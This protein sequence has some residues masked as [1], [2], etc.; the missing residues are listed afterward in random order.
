MKVN[1]AII[2]LSILVLQVICLSAQNAQPSLHQQMEWLRQTKK[3]NFVYDSSLKVDIPYAG[4][5]IRKMPVKKAL[6]TLFEKTDIEYVI[7]KN[8]V[9]LKRSQKQQIST[10]HTN[11]NHKVQQV[12]RRHTLSGYVRDKG[13]ESLINATVYD[14]THS[15]GT[16]TNEYG[17]FSITLP[18]GDHQIRFSYVGYAD[19]VEKINLSKDIHYN[20]S[21]QADSKL[22]EIVVNGDLNSPLL[23]TQ[24]GKR[25]FSSKDI[26][27]EFSLMSSPDVVKTLQRVSGVAEGQELASGLYVHGGNG[28]ENLFLIDGTPLY[29]INHALGLFSSFNTDVVKNIDFY[30]S[31]FPARYA[32]RLSSVIDVRTTDGDMNHFH[33]SYR[34]G[35]L[36]ASMQFEGPI[37]TGK[38]SYNIG[39]RRSW[40]DLLTRPLSSWLSDKDDKLSFGYYFMDLNAKVTHQF[41]ERSKVYLSIYHGN[42]S[43]NLKD[44]MDDSKGDGYQEGQSYYYEKAHSKLAWGNF[45]VALNWNYLFSP[46]LFANFTAVYTH[47]RSRLYV[48]DDE[49]LIYPSTDKASNIYHLEHRYHSTIDDLGYRM[50]FDNRP[51]AF[52]H[53][54]F[55]H[56]F[57]MH[58]FRPQTYM[59]LNYAGNSDAKVDTVSVT[60]H[61]RHQ[62]YELTAYA[63]DEIRLSRHWNV[64]VGFNLSSFHIGS[65]MFVNVDPRLALKY[66]VSQQVSMKASFT[67]MTQYVHKISNSYLDLPTDYWVPTTD[68]LNPMRSY[69]LAA[70][71]YAQ[72]SSHWL[73][74]LEG[75]Y[76][77]SR[78]LLQY[79]SW[80]GVEPPA[81]RW[82]AMVMDGKGVFYGIEADA[83]YRTDHLTLSGAYTL[84]WNKR[85]YEDF[86][87]DWYYDKFD[88]R[89]K[90]NLSLQYAFNKKLSC[91]AVWYYHTGNHATVPTQIASLP[92]LP[93]ANGQVSSTW[94]AGYGYVYAIPNNLTLP[95]YHRLD[96]GFDFRHVTK[97][98]HERIWNL[99]IY[100]V[101]CH[102][103]SMYVKI[104]YDEKRQQFRA[105][106]KAFVPILPSFSYTIKF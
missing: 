73:F 94:S 105:K 14:L 61:N 25:S 32:G 42:D 92:Q 30:K 10:F 104:D 87:P 51:N 13:G 7:S 96:L 29:Q 91:F 102:L 103:N 24:T 58:R 6:K 41:N 26:K 1:Q 78:H 27:T 59:Q 48:L 28:D 31:G 89:H 5:D 55:G 72:P 64:N 4:P 45:N 81:D 83:T 35:L 33:G 100:N 62:S 57:T 3:I 97:H 52:H 15:I 79:T 80:V 19:K 47:N 74:S 69:Q 23:T 22:P 84:S 46:K 88:N 38:T 67:Q 65:K 90:L 82:E 85:K 17:F 49:R 86:Y 93:D 40:A 8:Y 54:R 60:G 98:G 16:T 66:Q 12:R 95:A 36:D 70:G 68:K 101:Y 39:L 75:Y 77:Q 43:W 63:E 11:I 37:S 99:S 18:E 21:L 9:I 44:V 106:N 50:E 76:K 53:I 71:V 56:D 20:M 2:A 34:I